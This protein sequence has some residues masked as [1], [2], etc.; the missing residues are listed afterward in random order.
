[1]KHVFCG[2]WLVSLLTREWERSLQRRCHH[3]NDPVMAEH[4]D[5]WRV[6]IIT[7]RFEGSIFVIIIL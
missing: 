7:N 6:E 5:A 1:M 2:E 3:H 4:K